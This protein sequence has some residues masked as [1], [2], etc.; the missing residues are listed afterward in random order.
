MQNGAKM[1]AKYRKKSYIGGAP[2]GHLIAQPSRYAQKMAAAGPES[3]LVKW[4]KGRSIQQSRRGFL[5]RHRRRILDGLAGALADHLR[6]GVL[7]KDILPENIVISKAPS[8]KRPLV[9]IIDYGEAVPLNAENLALLEKHS[10][11]GDAIKHVVPS[12]SKYS[13]EA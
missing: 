3:A 9:K 7:H 12:F 1:A 11:Y 5:L 8:R 13:I 4:E 2:L 10:D 6:M